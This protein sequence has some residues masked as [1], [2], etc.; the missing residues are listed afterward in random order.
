MHIRVLY[1]P[2]NNP[3]TIHHISSHQF[4]FIKF[5][6]RWYS[7]AY[8]FI[9]TF[10][11]LAIQCRTSSASSHMCLLFPDTITEIRF[12]KYGDNFQCSFTISFLK[13]ATAVTVN[14]ALGSY[15]GLLSLNV[16][17]AIAMLSNLR[18]EK[19]QD[20]AILL[21]RYF[22]RRN[23]SIYIAYCY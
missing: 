4:F 8:H 19:N 16:Y 11:C 6:H 7:T 15:N 17:V 21:S 9:Q 2:T 12:T 23:F 20:I 1:L 3:P 22:V 13:Y 14:A 18:I 5:R 10:L